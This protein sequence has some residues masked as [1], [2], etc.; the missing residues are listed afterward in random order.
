MYDAEPC[1][2]FTRMAWH[3]AWHTGSQMLSS[4]LCSNS[5]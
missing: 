3:A 4:L 2:A 1:N 5:I